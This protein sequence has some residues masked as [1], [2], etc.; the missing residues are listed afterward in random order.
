MTKGVTSPESVPAP[1]AGKVLIE[2]GYIAPPSE[3]ASL[4]RE[5]TA[6]SSACVPYVGRA[7]K[8][9]LRARR[10][11]HKIAPTMPTTMKTTL[12]AGK[13]NYAL[14]QV[15]SG[16]GSGRLNSA[17]PQSTNMPP[18][19][20]AVSPA[21][22]RNHPTNATRTDR[23]APAT[24]AATPAER[25]LSPSTRAQIAGGFECGAVSVISRP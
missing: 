6:L 22:P 2:L 9:A 25:R 10:P 7:F 21:A 14:A 15:A 8:V 23:Q 16:S 24:R 4:R 19:S 11:T 13:G 12:A 3:S 1:T 18:G 5:S 17:G 20:T